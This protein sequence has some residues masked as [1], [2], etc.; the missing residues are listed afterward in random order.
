MQLKV[1]K[2]SFHRCCSIV[3]LFS[4]QKISHCT[5]QEPFWR[6]IPPGLPSG[7]FFCHPLSMTGKTISSSYLW[8]EDLLL[9]Y[10]RFSLMDFL[11]V[12]K[13]FYHLQDVLCI[14]WICLCPSVFKILQF[15]LFPFGRW[16]L[17]GI[18]RTKLKKY[19]YIL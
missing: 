7:D 1:R 11:E 13:D 6:L 2:K 16:G 4:T 18:S 19:I 3:T 14:P 15:F 5:T 8:V 9:R 12:Y 10:W 17:P